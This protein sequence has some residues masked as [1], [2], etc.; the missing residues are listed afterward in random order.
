MLETLLLECGN[1]GPGPVIAGRAVRFNP[2][3]DSKQR[4]S[5]RNTANRFVMSDSAAYNWGILK[6]PFED[7]HRSG[8]C[9]ANKQ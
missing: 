5:I 3:R 2:V 8:A 6:L 4:V 9:R 1:P 7:C